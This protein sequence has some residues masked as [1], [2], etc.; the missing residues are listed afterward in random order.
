MNNQIPYE[1]IAEII[2]RGLAD[3]NIAYEKSTLRDTP[4]KEWADNLIYEV[5]SDIVKKGD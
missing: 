2:E 4:D 5:Y 3:L 1:E